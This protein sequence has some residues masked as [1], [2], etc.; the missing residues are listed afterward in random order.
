[1]E[2]LKADIICAG[3]I[4]VDFIGHELQPIAHTKDY[5]RYLGGSP[6]NVA[7][8]LQR[9]GKSVALV[10]TC[11]QDGLGTYIIDKLKSNQVDCRY[12][13]QTME[14]PTSV[15]FISRSTETPEFIPFREA[16]CQIL[17]S[18]FPDELVQNCQVFHTTC[19]A[20]SK[21]P[22]REAILNRAAAAKA[23]GALLSI[24]LNYASKIWPDLLE[25]HQIIRSYLS[26]GALL[27]ISNDDC[28]RFFGTHKSESEIFSFFHNSGAKI[29]CLTKGADGVSVSAANGE[30]FSKPALP[31]EAVKDT[32]GAGD[33]FWSG[34][35]FAYLSGY[36]LP[37]CT[38]AAQK[39]AHI[40]LQNVGRIPDNIPLRE[41]VFHGI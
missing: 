31:I 40:K 28:Y 2:V 8:N 24:D 13:R 32:T 19:F 16:D 21:N 18:Q 12:I 17:T 27:K 5:H 26:H 14:H 4:L 9:L 39:L 10:A 29:I 11:G 7:V 35:I 15:I 23:A 6:T 33:A 20:L 34:F 3:E 1:M 37:D 25:A 41:A 36:S 22:A 30:T 38:K